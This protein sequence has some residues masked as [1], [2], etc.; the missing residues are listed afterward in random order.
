M[1]DYEAGVSC[2]HVL[3]MCLNTFGLSYPK[4]SYTEVGCFVS[5]ALYVNTPMSQE[6]HILY[7]STKHFLE[8]KCKIATCD[9]SWGQKIIFYAVCMVLY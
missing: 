3:I 7:V 9:T 4:V 5:Q 1:V 2:Q 6:E 8:T